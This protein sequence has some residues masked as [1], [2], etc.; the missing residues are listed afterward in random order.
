MK[1]AVIG[2]GGAMGGVWAAHLHEGGHDV[3]I[4]DVAHEAVA[5]I[6]RD[7][8]VIET[9]GQ[10]DRIVRI[11]AVSSAAEIGPVDVVIVFT[12][13]H[14]TRAAIAGA[15]PLLGPDTTV[16]SLQNGWGSA[17]T[18]AE[19][20]D[21]ARLVIGVSYHGATLVRPGV[22]RHT[23][24]GGGTFAGAYVDGGSLDRAGV[25]AQAMS[26]AGIPTVVAADVK[27]HIWKKL[28]LN[29]AASPVAALTGLTTGAMGTS[30]GLL[31][32]IEVLAAEAVAVGQAMGF[33]LE[34]E[35]RMSVIRGIFAAGG[36]GKASM[37]QDV[38]ARRPT[39]IAAINGAIVRE[40]EA[41]GIP[42]PLNRAMVALIQGL[43][44]S[45]ML[46]E[47]GRAG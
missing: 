44:A 28:V 25:V 20:I 16:V 1:I 13:V 23:A 31:S 19:V 9:P 4:L 18:L 24:S 47:P 12:K 38:E 15:R 21:P 37:L 42:V 10:P 22:V 7:G 36:A 6:N 39:E 26:A 8:L 14:H 46:A 2:G 32:T 35:E 3:R 29:A 43:E 41:R 40:G 27:T 34:M 11:P 45:W 5:A 33:A 30:P 17:D